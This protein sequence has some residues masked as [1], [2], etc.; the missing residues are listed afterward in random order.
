VP[1]FDGFDAKAR[2]AVGALMR[3][4]NAPHDAVVVRQGARVGGAF[5]VV[6]GTMRVVRTMPSG[7]SVDVRDVTSGVLFGLLSCLDG[8]PR[9]TSVMARG[10][11]RVAELPRAAVIELL[12]GHTA[13]ALVFQVAICQALFREVRITNTRLAEL[14]AVPDAELATTDLEPIAPLEELDDLTSGLEPLGDE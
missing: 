10:D 5:L 6:S 11:A 9:S 13:A 8:G 14:A 3:T 12:E 7:R 2:E 1:G 4:A